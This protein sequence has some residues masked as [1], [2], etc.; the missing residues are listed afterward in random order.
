MKQFVRIMHKSGDCYKYVCNF[1]SGLS[2]EK[3]KT[4]IFNGTEISQFINDPNLI[5]V[6]TDT[7]AS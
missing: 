4:G 2:M 7:V 5:N 6:I 1:F 3:Q